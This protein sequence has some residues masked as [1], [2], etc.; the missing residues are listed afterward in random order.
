MADSCQGTERVA[1]SGAGKI[2][3]SRSIERALPSTMSSISSP[4]TTHCATMKP[5]PSAS[6]NREAAE[7]TEV[8][9]EEKE[10]EE[11]EELALGL[12]TWKLL[13]LLTTRGWQAKRTWGRRPHWARIKSCS[14]ARALSSLSCSS[15]KTSNE[16]T[17]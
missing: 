12:E 6:E 16:M 3:D 10:E 15:P 8:E 5:V 14:C 1:R 2:R 11:E 7:E 13:G 9:E 17:N 4:D